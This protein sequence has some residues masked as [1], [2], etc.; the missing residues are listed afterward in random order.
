[1][2]TK[3]YLGDGVDLLRDHHTVLVKAGTA[4]VPLTRKVIEELY[5]RTSDL[6]DTAEAPVPSRTVPLMVVRPR[7]DEEMDEWA[8]KRG[9]VPPKPKRETPLEELA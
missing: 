8:A 6:Q 4:A 5:R 1:M 3:T 7:R 9:G 2:L